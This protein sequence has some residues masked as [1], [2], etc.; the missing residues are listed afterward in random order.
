MPRTLLKIKKLMF[1]IEDDSK[2]FPSPLSRNGIYFLISLWLVL[3]L[4]LANISCRKWH[5]IA[6]EAVPKEICGFYFTHLKHS[7]LQSNCHSIKNPSYRER[8]PPLIQREILP[9]LKL[10]KKV[11]KM[12][13]TALWSTALTEFPA[14]SHY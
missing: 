3:L 4:A 7:I 12:K 8:S 9:T 13:T 10:P 2:V 5:H 14:N 11:T 6:S 1:L